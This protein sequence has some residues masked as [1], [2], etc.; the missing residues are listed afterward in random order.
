[1]A[2]QQLCG[3]NPVIFYTVYIFETAGT[4][5]DKH[6]CAIIVGTANFASTIAANLVIDKVGRKVLLIISDVLMA[7]SLV[8]LATFFY[9]KEEPEFGFL[10][11]DFGWVPLVSFIVF[12]SSFSLGLGPVPWIM[13]AEIF[14][15]RIRAFAVGIT[16]AFHWILTFGIIKVF[17]SFVTN[18][19]SHTAFYLCAGI[20]VVGLYFIVRKVPETRGRSLEQI[21][22]KLLRPKK[23][24]KVKAEFGPNGILF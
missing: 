13:T 11:Q 22:R 7:A 18:F 16:T 15:M 10:T 2:L 8:V 19:G 12:V 17:P 1:M 23:G 5:L 21:E 20:C 14:P 24:K 3:I 6:L 9:L 4:T